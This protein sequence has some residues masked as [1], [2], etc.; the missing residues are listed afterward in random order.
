M[1]AQ[2][3]LTASLKTTQM[4]FH[5][6]VNDLTD[7]ELLERPGPGCNH[8]AWQLGHLISSNSSILNTIAPGAAP[9]L[10]PGFDDQH[11]KSMATSQDTSGFLTKD[12]YLDLFRKL[13]EATLAAFAHLSEDDLDKPSPENWRGKFPTMGSLAV[14]LA[15]HTMMHVGQWVPI[16][17]RLQKPVLI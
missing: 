15:S 17:R 12:Q 3:V 4:I 13:D 14:L 10:P 2:D 7:A 5:S 16:R 1:K 6:Y 11:S 9:T 8:L